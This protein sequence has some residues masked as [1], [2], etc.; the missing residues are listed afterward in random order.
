MIVFKE[1]KNNLIRKT[2]NNDFC[3]ISSFLDD[4]ARYG[5]FLS[6]DQMITPAHSSFEN[7]HDYQLVLS[8]IF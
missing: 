8:D 7:E 3:K 2:K 4:F 6:V 5:D 1:V